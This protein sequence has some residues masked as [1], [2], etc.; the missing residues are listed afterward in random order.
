MPTKKDP[1]N[2][3]GAI[4]HAIANRALSDH[5]AKNIFGNVNYAKHF[6]QGTVVGFFDGRVPGGKNAIWKLMVDFE[7]PSDGA[8]VELKRVDIHCQH[9]ILGAVPAGKNP[10]CSMTFTDLIGDPDHVM[11]GSSTDLP[12]AEAR[13]AAASAA[14]TSTDNDD[15]DADADADAVAAATRVS[16]LPAPLVAAP[17]DDDIGIVLPPSQPP[18]K[19]KRKRKKATSRND[20]STAMPPPT[21]APAAKKSKAT[22]KKKK[23][24]YPSTFV[25]TQCGWFRPTA[26][27]IASWRLPTSKNGSPVSLRRSPDRRP[28]RP[29]CRSSSSVIR[30]TSCH[31]HRPRSHRPLLIQSR[32]WWT[33]NI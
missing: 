8:K 31:F 4:V 1:R 20:A 16:L 27:S 14:A 25:S 2:E 11:K 6:L 26:R 22:K 28:G 12:N 15:D 18:V 19:T 33:T 13:A 32:R 3:A 23:P 10:L 29:S 21:A 7:M 24:Q 9:C 17:A 30:G 5:T